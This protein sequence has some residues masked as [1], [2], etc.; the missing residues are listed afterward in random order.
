MTSTQQ[1]VTVIRM[2]TNATSVTAPIG[3][4]VTYQRFIYQLVNNNRWI[5]SG[6]VFSIPKK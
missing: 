3:Y 2:I 6:I 5:S 4:R 1:A